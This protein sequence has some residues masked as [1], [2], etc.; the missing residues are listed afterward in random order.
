MPDLKKL[1]ASSALSFLPHS[2]ANAPDTQ[3]TASEQEETN[4]LA[5]TR[6][7]PYLIPVPMSRPNSIHSTSSRT[8]V[9]SDD[10]VRSI[11]RPDSPRSSRS[12]RIV[13]PRTHDYANLNNMEN[14]TFRL[15]LNLATA[16]PPLSNIPEPER[17]WIRIRS[18]NLGYHLDGEATQPATAPVPAP[19]PDTGAMAEPHSVSITHSNSPIPSN[20]Y[21]TPEFGP[22]HNVHRTPTPFPGAHSDVP[23]ASESIPAQS[24]P[25]AAG[26]TSRPNL[27]RLFHEWLTNPVTYAQVSATLDACGNDRIRSYAR[28]YIELTEGLRNGREELRELEEQ[29]DERHKLL[30]AMEWD[31]CSAAATL[32]GLR[33]ESHLFPHVVPPERPVDSHSHSSTRNVSDSSHH[34]SSSDHRGS[35]SN[36][37]TASS[38]SHQQSRD[39]IPIRVV[40]SPPDRELTPSPPDGSSGYAYPGAMGTN[41]RVSQSR[42]HHDPTDNN[43]SDYYADRSGNTSAQAIHSSTSQSDESPTRVGRRDRTRC[44]QCGSRSHLKKDCHMRRR[45]RTRARQ[46]DI[47]EEEIDHLISSLMPSD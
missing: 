39:N 40:Q 36:Y 11:P 15:L 17:E 43:A 24:D 22:V 7:R 21:H 46:Q 25:D 37:H 27:P 42:L 38:V 4:N 19:N 6:Y 13:F 34:S 23:P 31:R 9:G 12:E 29:A 16:Q 5:V 41:L 26:E 10:E 14:A 8:R 3:Y 20:S 2:M 45:R 1:N 32:I 18:R 33:A 30:G 35:H 44:W 47:I 28:R